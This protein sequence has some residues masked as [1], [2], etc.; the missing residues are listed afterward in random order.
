MQKPQK[1]LR[2][3]QIPVCDLTCRDPQTWI[4]ATNLSVRSWEWQCLY[5]FSSP[6]AALCLWGKCAGDQLVIRQ[7]AAT[8]VDLIEDLEPATGMIWKASASSIILFKL[9]QISVAV[10]W[11][12]SLYSIIFIL[13]HSYFQV[14]FLDM[15]ESNVF[16]FLD[17][18]HL[19][20]PIHKRSRPRPIPTS[21]VPLVCCLVENSNLEHQNLMFLSFPAYLGTKWFASFSEGRS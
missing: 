20:F 12:T 4:G 6:S 11:H 14:F 16:P 18:A 10:G 2:L 7:S 21:P 19:P 15:F 1:P 13:Y 9:K 17:Q 5:Q 3:P 8:I